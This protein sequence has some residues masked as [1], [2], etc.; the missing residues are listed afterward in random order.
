MDTHAGR[1]FIDAH[2]RILDQRRAA[3]LFDGGPTEPVINAVLAYL[4]TDGGFGHGLEPDTRDPNSQPLYAQVALESVHSVGAT[5]P[6]DVLTT[7][8][9]HLAAVA[10]PNGTPGLPIM[11]PSFADHPRASHW[12]EISEF[13]PGHNPTAAIAGLLHAAGT[14]HPWLDD[15]TEWCV[16]KIDGD[17]LDDESAHTIGCALTLLAH[18]PDRATAERLADGVFARLPDAPYFQPMPAPGEYGLT[19]LDFAPLPDSPWRARFDAD[20]VAAHLDALAAEQ[21]P[22]GGWPIRWEPP[23]EPSMWEWRGM[24]TVEAL[25]VLGRNR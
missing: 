6:V 21:Q 13:P 2:A 7:L 3:A 5:L 17:G 23:T 4:N 14:T 12:L 22:D 1:A 25:N 16:T 24:V 20:Q 18:L 10:E 19:P 8:C 15:A 9:D 11:V